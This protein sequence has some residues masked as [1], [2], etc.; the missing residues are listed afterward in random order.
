L[1]ANKGSIT[2]DMADEVFSSSWELTKIC[3]QY[4]LP[5]SHND[6]QFLLYAIQCNAHQIVNPESKAIALG[7]FPYTSM[8]NH[9]CRP[10]CIKLFLIQPNCPPKLIMRAIRDIDKGE[11]LCYSYVNLYQSTECRREQLTKAYSF[12]CIC[13]RCSTSIDTDTVVE[14]ALNY[15]DS[16][17]PAQ[18]NPKTAAT[19]IP[20]NF[21]TYSFLN[22]SPC[23][24]SKAISE[25]NNN[26][27]NGYDLNSESEIKMTLVS[28]EALSAL[29]PIE[30]TGT[31]EVEESHPISYNVLNEIDDF[32][33]LLTNILSSDIQSIQKVLFKLKQFLNGTKVRLLHPAHKNL[34]QCYHLYCLTANQLLLHADLGKQGIEESDL[35]DASKDDENEYVVEPEGT[36]RRFSYVNELQ[37]IQYMIQGAVGYGI[38]ALGCLKKYIGH[39]QTEIGTYT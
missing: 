35:F 39:V 36:D 14:N 15:T 23:T 4:N 27:L 37:D 8:M 30:V 29:E 38:L 5:L 1:E 33:S 3:N 16:A 17:V 19:S 34:F 31:G 11:E 10:N 7:L 21:N 12:H 9:S 2:P 25:N 6:I 24:S 18:T 26:H 22:G 20:A 28:D 32:L 13:Q